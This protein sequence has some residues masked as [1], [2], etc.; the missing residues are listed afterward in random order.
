MTSLTAR[1]FT[2]VAAVAA[3]L[4]L[5]SCGSSESTSDPESPTGIS[6]EQQRNQAQDEPAIGGEPAGHN[7]VDVVFVTNMIPHHQ[8]ALELAGIA[9]DRSGNQE[10]IDLAAEI[11]AAQQPEIDTMKALLVQWNADPDL[12][13]THGDQGESP[14]KGM[15]DDA[16][17]TQL[18][19][20]NGPEFDNL[21]LESMIAHHEGA[22]GM[23]NEQLASG[24]NADATTLAQTIVDTQQAE[25]DQMRQMLGG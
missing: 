17:M 24:E 19:S 22:I 2:V 13:A 1:L 8:Q 25:I 3:A 18:E 11:S 7:P 10:L 16:T 9:P 12:G 21:W 6:E 14:M 4:F 23:A 5:S 15:V 20:L